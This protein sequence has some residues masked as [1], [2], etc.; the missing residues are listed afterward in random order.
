MKVVTNRL[1]LF[2]RRKMTSKTTIVTCLFLAV[3]SIGVAQAP[4]PKN[5]C[6]VKQHNQL[7]DKLKEA[8][9]SE[10]PKPNSISFAARAANVHDLLSAT[11][12]AS[13][14]LDALDAN[15]AGISA[16][17]QEAVLTKLRDL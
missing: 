4:T 7:L 5:A 3:C 8:E 17:D 14:L 11:E 6:D 10:E 16:R 2:G 1:D 15:P 13:N 12:L 9:A